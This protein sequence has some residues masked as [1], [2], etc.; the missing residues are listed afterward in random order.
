LIFP[1][2]EFPPATCYDSLFKPVGSTTSKYCG[3]TTNSLS[4]RSSLEINLS[5]TTNLFPREDA[6]LEEDSSLWGDSWGWKF[7][8]KKSLD[9]WTIPVSYRSRTKQTRHEV[10]QRH[11]YHPKRNPK[12]HGSR[13]KHNGSRPEYPSRTGRGSRGSRPYII[14]TTRLLLG[15]D[16]CCIV[17]WLE[18]LLNDGICMIFS[19]GQLQGLLI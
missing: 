14:V 15:K 9:P 2:D 8:R 4:N 16:I 10:P 12:F 18:R 1:S 7:C 6:S 17:F 3:P 11:R 13:P 5:L 19:V